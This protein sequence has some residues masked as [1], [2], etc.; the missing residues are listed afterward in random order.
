MLLTHLQMRGSVDVYG[1]SGAHATLDLSTPEL[2]RRAHA[3]YSGAVNADCMLCTPLLLMTPVHEHPTVTSSVINVVTVGYVYVMHTTRDI[4][5][6]DMLTFCPWGVATSFKT[7]QLI[8]TIGRLP[9][10]FPESGADTYENECLQ[11]E[12]FKMIAAHYVVSRPPTE[13]LYSLI[14]VTIRLTMR[15]VNISLHPDVCD[16]PRLPTTQ[17]LQENI[18]AM[19]EDLDG[20]PYV[21]APSELVLLALFTAT[22]VITTLVPIL[23]Q[24]ERKHMLLVHGWMGRK[25]IKVTKGESYASHTVAYLCTA[26][27]LYKEYPQPWMKEWVEVLQLFH[28]FDDHVREFISVAVRSGL[29]VLGV[30]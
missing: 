16:V 19:L 21:Q 13:K 26:A 30:V 22:H 2:C 29:A 12:R 24:A 14:I 3:L 6:G 5:C 15:I 4:K 11:F 17:Q 7:R 25:L 27:V 8:A 23:P 20:V 18:P 28:T 1:Q 9:S 10:L